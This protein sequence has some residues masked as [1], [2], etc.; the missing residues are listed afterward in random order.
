IFIGA[1]H[2]QGYLEELLEEAEVRE[3]LNAEK[4]DDIEMGSSAVTKRIDASHFWSR[5]Q[6]NPKYLYYVGQPDAYKL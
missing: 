4:I 1:A 6:L 5:L 2:I 3:M